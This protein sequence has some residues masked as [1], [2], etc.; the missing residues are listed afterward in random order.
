MDWNTIHWILYGIKAVL[1]AWELVFPE[2]F[3]WDPER[4]V[5]INHTLLVNNAERRALR[6]LL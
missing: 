2:F 4:A 1:D 6:G 3:G 5:H